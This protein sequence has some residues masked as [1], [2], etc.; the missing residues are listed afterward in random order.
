M[1]MDRPMG[2]VSEMVSGRAGDWLLGQ[3]RG[4]AEAP[5]EMD[6]ATAAAEVQATVRVTVAAWDPLTEMAKTDGTDP[7]C[8]R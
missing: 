6:T 7:M 3:H 2:L 4:E 5:A 8:I 1:E